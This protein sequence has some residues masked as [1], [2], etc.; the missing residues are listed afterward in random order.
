MW[1]RLA[2]RPGPRG[3]AAAGGGGGVGGQDQTP[4]SVPSVILM[5]SSGEQRRGPFTGA[6]LHRPHAFVFCIEFD[7]RTLHVLY[8][9]PRRVETILGF[10]RSPPTNQESRESGRLEAGSQAGVSGDSAA[11]PFLLWPCPSSH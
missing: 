7:F 3:A 2:G 6:A 5:R 10:P 9:A 8:L 1:C 4:C 11:L